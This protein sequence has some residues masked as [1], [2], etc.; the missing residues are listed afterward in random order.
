M[1]YGLQL[2]IQN[3]IIKKKQFNIIEIFLSAER[4]SHCSSPSRKTKTRHL[5]E[6]LLRSSFSQTVF[7]LTS[8]LFLR[9]NFSGLFQF[10]PE[11]SMFVIASSSRNAMIYM[12]DTQACAHFGLKRIEN[13]KI[14]NRI[15]NFVCYF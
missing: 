8:I 2:I 15:L 1:F 9:L 13:F 5:P 10:G 11:R 3:C 6:S 4:G 14:F 12:K 7:F